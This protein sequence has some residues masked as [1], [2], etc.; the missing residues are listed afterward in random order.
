M[1]INNISNLPNKGNTPPKNNP[2]AKSKA[3]APPQAVKFPRVKKSSTTFWLKTLLFFLGIALIVLIRRM[4][5]MSFRAITEEEA[6]E[7]AQDIKVTL[8]D[9]E[10]TLLATGETQKLKVGKTVKV[11]G[12]YKKKLNKGNSPR[13][14][15]TNQLYLMELPDGQRAYGPLMET[16]VGQLN[17]LTVTDSAMQSTTDTVV[18]TAVKKLKQNPTVQA[19]GEESRFD[20]A[21]TL[22]G[23]Q[24]TYALEDLHIYFPQRVAYLA[25]GLREE[26]FTVGRDTL[27]E[28][29]KDAQSLKKFFLYDIRP[30]TKRVGFYVFPRYQVWNEFLLQR[31]FRNLMVFF[32]YLLEIGL[33]VL[34]IWRRHE[35]I[36]NFKT[37]RKLNR[38][39]RKAKRGDAQACYEVAEACFWGFSG[40]HGVRKST[41]GEE[42]VW[43]YRHAADLG[44]G[45]ACAKMG[46]FYENGGYGEEID[47]FKA[48]DYYEKGAALGDKQ[49]QEGVDRLTSLLSLGSKFGQSYTLAL[50]DSASAQS[51]LGYYYA[52]GKYVRQ[53]GRE[54]YKWYKK[55]ADQGDPYG[56][57]GLG[58]CYKS[59]Y[60]VATN[61]AT[62]ISLF[63]KALDLGYDHPEDA[64]ANI[65]T[66]Y[67]KIDDFTQALAYFRK[68]ADLGVADSM[69]NIGVLYHKGQGVPKSESE[70]IRWFKKAAALGDDSAIDALKQLG[71]SY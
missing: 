12:V 27:A 70:A 33:I 48:Q 58:I 63:Q 36:D 5:Q 22:E 20:Y 55:S 2:S 1:D 26:D 32:A 21:Y 13:V 60:G 42:S 8:A 24:E 47:Y 67:Y 65:G 71:V 14:Y 16:A 28:N 19:T 46:D 7:L 49:C 64:Y 45:E 53:N 62:A 18:I 3:P 23:R 54:A 30:F 52:E 29:K 59:G 68:A 51:R 69:Y 6:L 57:H 35:I 43:W 61:Y 41:Q 39:L 56:W 66:C 17:V 25:K 37:N 4:D 34:L 9:Q 11:L 38:N 31:W 40:W 15:W 44:H 10:V 50:A